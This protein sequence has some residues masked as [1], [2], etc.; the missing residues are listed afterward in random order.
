MYKNLYNISIEYF[1]KI[2]LHIGHK[3]N[4]LNTKMNPYIF[5]I[6][7][8]ISIFDI[9][10]LWKPFRYLFYSLV[11]S[12]KRRNSFFLVGT[13]ANLP[14]AKI[15][16][17]L[18]KQ[19]PVKVKNFNPFYI[20]GYVDKKWVGGI[21]SNWQVT[22]DFIK[23][24]EKSSKKNSKRY[25]RYLRYLSGIKNLNFKPIPDLVIALNPNDEAI[26][27]A[28][29][30]QIPIFGFVDSNTN[31]DEYLYPFYGNDDALESIEFFCDFLNDAVKEGRLKEQELFFFYIMQKLKNK[32]AEDKKFN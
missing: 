26:K 13:N 20:V 5:G 16:N 18:M 15:I 23:Y 8:N 12:T 32:I 30:L 24:M 1:L 3:Q 31:P 17:N 6:R 29:D 25:K 28:K 14:M 4:K 10:K 7:H 2:R 27:E 21:F 22:L 11:E 9:E 19:Y